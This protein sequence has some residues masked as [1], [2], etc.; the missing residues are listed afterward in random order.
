MLTAPSHWI[1]SPS[2]WP[3]ILTRTAPSTWMRWT[4]FG[5]AGFKMWKDP[6]RPIWFLSN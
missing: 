5:G 4:G 6:R 1:A 2:T 3:D